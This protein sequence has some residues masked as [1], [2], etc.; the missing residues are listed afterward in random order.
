MTPLRPSLGDDCTCVIAP[1]P[2]P[3][4]VRP[5]RVPSPQALEAK[6]LLPLEPCRI[7]DLDGLVSTEAR[8]GTFPVP[9]DPDDPEG[10][11]IQLAVAVVPAIATK[12]KPDP[13]FLI[14][15]GPGQGSIHGF[16]P[17]LGAFAGIRRERDLVLVDQRGTGDSNRLDCDMPDDALESGEIPPA[18]LR[19]LGK[20][21]CRHCRPRAVLHDEHRGAR[22][23]RGARGARLPR[24]NIYGG[25]YGTRVAQHYARRYPDHTRTVVLDGVVPPALALLPNI[26]IESQRTLDAYSRAARPTRNATGA[27]PALDRA[28]REARCRASRRD[29]S[30]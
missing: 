19:K 13:L 22:P 6:P 27:F 3:R 24:M 11:H 18:E 16:A 10:T 17:L 25:S 30:R 26:A 9:E 23:R 1:A 28:V 21:A 12:A 2:A 8:C 29:R 7:A 20:A 5:R 14:A 4:R 15:G